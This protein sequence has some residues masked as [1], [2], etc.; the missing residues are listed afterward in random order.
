[1][2]KILNKKAK[3]AVL[4][5][6]SALLIFA[7]LVPLV[8]YIG[9]QKYEYE[10]WSPNAES[11]LSDKEI[12]D[13][14]GRGAD[15]TE[16]DYRILYEQTGLTRV[17]V[18]RVISEYGAERIL[19]YRDS[20][21]CDY[22]LVEDPF[23]V[24]CN[25]IYI[26]GYAEMVPLKNG[27]I[28]VTS[29]TNFAMWDTGHAALVVEE[30]PY[31]VLEAY[32]FDNGSEICSTYELHTRP[33]FIVLRL[34]DGGDTAGKIA[35]YAKD[36]LLGIKYDPTA[37]VLSLKNPKSLK[38]TQCAHIVWYAYR[39]YGIDIDANGGLVVTPKD[40]ANSDKLEVVQVFGFDPEALWD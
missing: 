14:L 16:E 32:N 7:L 18:D 39:Q 1:M 28:I 15:M 26:D 24:F 25:A 29:A 33:D 22:E 6:V 30:S 4:I 3:K 35:E 37:G 34:K 5:S 10:R 20:Y 13:I 11:K 12:L 8:F 2:Q 23:S 9:Y 19:D 38:R 31:Q 21:F 40:I 17:G 27:D 36:E